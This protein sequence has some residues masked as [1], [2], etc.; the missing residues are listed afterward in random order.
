MT[1]AE[2]Y[3]DAIDDQVDAMASD[4]DVTDEEYKAALDDIMSRCATAREHAR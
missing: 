3:V 2:R 4:P 1:A